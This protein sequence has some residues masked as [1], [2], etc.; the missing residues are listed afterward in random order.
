MNSHDAE[1]QEL[2]RAIGLLGSNTR[3]AR[4]LA[5]VGAR[6]F[7]GQ[8]AELTE[9]KIAT[10]VFGRSAQRFDATEDAVVRVEVHRLRKKLREIYEKDTR[11]QG[12]Q[13]S[14]PPGTYVP[15]FTPLSAPPPASDAP[16]S[17]PA[18]RWRRIPKWTILTVVIVSAAIASLMIRDGSQPGQTAV[19]GAAPAQTQSP[20]RA[21]PG[22]ISELH[23][24]A[25]YHG[26]EV[27]DNSGVRWTPDRYFASGGQWSR[28]FGLVRGTSRPFLFANWRTGEFGYDIPVKP[29]VYELRLFFVSP[30]RIGEE[31]LGGFQVA[32][33]GKP[34]L[35]DYDINE[36]ANGTD[37]ADELVF[38][39]VAPGEDGFIRL[40]FSN[41][42]ASPLLNALEL[43][44]GT[45]GK[46]HPI[47]ILTQPTS[48]VDHK[49]QRWRADDYY[50]NGFRS[51]E[52][53]KVSGTEDPELFGAERFGHFSY[54]IPVD[55]RG[56]YTVILHF[57]ELYY[58]A[59]LAGAGGVGSRVF[60]VFCNGQTLLRDFDIYKEAGSLRVVTKTFTN[61]VPSALG[62]INLDFEPVVNN[63]TVSAI[64]VI[65]ESP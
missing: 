10:E 31:K 26:S 58:G 23:I 60:H 37:I 24:L 7:Q 40:W 13:I 36:S 46:L 25:G 3:H 30:Y 41:H 2:A 21:A 11:T 47:R 50:L 59:Q 65:E 14:L 22:A 61:I 18:S 5:Y 34:L 15:S 51:T 12:L 38:R 17:E 48:F 53:R 16:V 52:R 1:Q 29:G 63:A 44:P 64:E 54:A 28:D 45:P 9:F 19:P 57:A 20:E 4:L 8:E 35:Q 43:V 56:R 39:D 42:V 27:I 55:R 33:H 32:L 49:G 6:Y 62:K